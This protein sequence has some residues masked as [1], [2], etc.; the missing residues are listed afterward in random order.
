MSCNVDVDEDVDIDVDFEKLDGIYLR[1]TGIGTRSFSDQ[2][3]GSIT[4]VDI[5]L[6]KT[7]LNKRMI[8]NGGRT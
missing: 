3:I 6:R 4:S 7:L 1:L 2:L 8:I 5:K